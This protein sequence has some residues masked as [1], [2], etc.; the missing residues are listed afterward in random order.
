MQKNIFPTL[1]HEKDP[2]GPTKGNAQLTRQ[3]DFSFT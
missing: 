2:Q 1:L 3:N